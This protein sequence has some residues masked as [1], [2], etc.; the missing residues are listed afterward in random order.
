MDIRPTK[1]SGVSQTYGSTAL[2]PRLT[3][4]CSSF[5]HG[6]L[7]VPSKEPLELAPISLDQEA[8][9]VR[10]FIDFVTARNP[11]KIDLD[12][13]RM[14][15]AV[16]LCDR[17]R[18][19]ESKDTLSLSLRESLRH[20]AE[21]NQKKRKYWEGVTVDA[22]A[23]FELAAKRSD[24]ALAKGAIRCFSGPRLQ[25]DQLVCAKD[26]KA[27]YAEV[28]KDWA[29]ALIR[30]SLEYKA[31]YHGARGQWVDRGW[32]KADFSTMADNFE[33]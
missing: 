18:I 12:I 5:I 6:L 16:A 22:W 24:V 30:V 29:L 13:T 20:Y 9:V 21:R 14:Q 2:A 26:T 1:V 8:T 10:H 33:V 25:P 32:R 23:I 15:G 3:L 27:L 31:V 28:P 4:R 19:S 11:V 17:F 7:S